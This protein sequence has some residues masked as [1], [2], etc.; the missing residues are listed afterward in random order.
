MS[1]NVFGTNNAK[2]VKPLENGMKKQQELLEECSLAELFL[3]VII[4]VHLIL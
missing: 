4:T 2:T 3:Q 1:G